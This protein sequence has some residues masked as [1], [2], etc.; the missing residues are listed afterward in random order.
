[1][2]Q[3]HDPA[4]NRDDDQKPDRP[5]R[6]STEPRGSEG[7]ARSDKTQTDPASGEQD[8]RAPAP[9]QAETDQTDGARRRR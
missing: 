2:S 4:Y 3:P 5:Q 8:T 7:S 6:T 9:S 1:M